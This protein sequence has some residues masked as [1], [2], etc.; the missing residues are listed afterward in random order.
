MYPNIVHTFLRFS[1]TEGDLSAVGRYS[2]VEKPEGSWFHERLR[3][4]SGDVHPDR[5]RQALRFGMDCQN[6]VLRGREKSVLLPTE[7][8]YVIDN[9]NRRTFELEMLRVERLRHKHTILDK[10]K[11]AGRDIDHV[12]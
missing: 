3:V 6:S 11:V 2:H 1:N 10:Q 5:L 9:R 4:F 8:R 7:D 12:G